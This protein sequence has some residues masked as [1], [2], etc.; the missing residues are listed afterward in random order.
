[1]HVVPLVPADTVTIPHINLINMAPNP[2]AY[3]KWHTI[4]AGL[5]SGR[6]IEERVL[7]EIWEYTSHS[8]YYADKLLQNQTHT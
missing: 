8:F 2:L 4:K 7:W 1:M 6:N 5:H 3:T